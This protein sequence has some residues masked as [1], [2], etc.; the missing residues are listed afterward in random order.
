MEFEGKSLDNITIKVNTDRSFPL[1]KT[2]RNS[3]DKI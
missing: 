2:S 1:I 3:I